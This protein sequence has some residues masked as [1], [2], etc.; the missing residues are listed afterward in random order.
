MATTRLMSIHKNKSRTIL[1]TLAQSIDYGEDGKKTRDGKLVSSYECDPK[2]AA[3]EF[4]LAKKQYLNITGR[5]QGKDIL[6]Y[7]LRQSFKPGEITAEEANRISLE[8]AMSLT[9]GKHAVIVCTHEDKEHIHSHIYFNSTALDC[10]RKFRNFWGSSFAIRRLSDRICLENGLSIVENPKPSKK[11]RK[12]WELNKKP[13]FRNKIKQTIDLTLEKK[14][15]DFNEFV[16]LMQE[17]GYKVKNKTQLK[18]LAPGQ[19][20]FSRC[21]TLGDDYTEQAIIERISGKRIGAA[22]PRA[23]EFKQSLVIDLQNSI[24]AQ[25]SPGYAHWAKLFNLKQA[26]QTLAF[27][28][29][30]GLD[31]YDKL[32]EQTTQATEKFN[33]LSLQIKEK[34]SRLKDISEMQKYISQY[35]KTRNTYAEYRK[36]GYSKKFLA[37]HESDIILHKAAKSFFDKQ[38]LGKLPTMK[39]LKTE[40]ATLLSEK[41]KLYSEYHDIKKSMQQL[42]TAKQNADWLLDKKAVPQ[43]AKESERQ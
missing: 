18:F 17:A 2:T 41:K 33:D 39:N 9:K 14:P 43:S 15:P 16:A 3:E 12:L 40:Y 32:A 28:Q 30:S 36:N 7:H 24:K 13:S 19:K 37:E 23:N 11:K 5:K 26:A 34:E 31:D 10:T 22:D 6:L 8:L 27:L 42:V 20:R 4:L 38:G 21:D 1:E 29:E 25:N 35:S